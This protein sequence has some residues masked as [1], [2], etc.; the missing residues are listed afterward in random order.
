MIDFERELSRVVASSAL[1]WALKNEKS[2]H[3]A[4]I[5]TVPSQLCG[6]L[7][8]QIKFELENLNKNKIE[9]T[10]LEVFELQS[11]K[12]LVDLTESQINGEKAIEKRNKGVSCLIIAPPPP[13]TPPLP[14]EIPSSIL[15]A[16]EILDYLQLI[17]LAAQEFYMRCGRAEV[18]LLNSFE[19]EGWLNGSSTRPGNT[20]AWLYIVAMVALGAERKEIGRELWRVGLIPDVGT[21]SGVGDFTKRLKRNEE[22]VKALGGVTKGKT[23]SVRLTAVNVALTPVTTRVIS[24]LSLR[25]LTSAAGELG[26]CKS[27][28]SDEL[29]LDKWDLEPDFGDLESLSILPFR[30]LTGR[31]TSASKLKQDDPKTF[32]EA[33]FANVEFTDEGEVRKPPSVQVH[34]ETNPKNFVHSGK[35]RVSLVIPGAYRREDEPPLLVKI[36]KDRKERKHSL[37]L[38]ISRDDLP[39]GVF[40]GSLLVAI[41][42]AALSEEDDMVMRLKNGR[43][44]SVESDEFELRFATDSGGPDDSAKISTDDSVSPA[45]AI[46]SVALGEEAAPFVRGY[47]LDEKRSILEIQFL[48]SQ[49]RKVAIRTV[50]IIPRLLQIQKKLISDCADSIYVKLSLNSNTIDSVGEQYVKSTRIPDILLNARIEY[51]KQVKVF[52]KTRTAALVETLEWDT[53]VCTALDEYVAIYKKVLAECDLE[54]AAEILLLDTVQ[55]EVNVSREPLRTTVIL[56]THP[57]RSLWLREYWFKLMKWHQQVLRLDVSERA[58]AIDIELV[59]RISL[60]NLPFISKAEGSEFNIYLDEVAFGYGIYVSPDD[61]DHEAMVSL[62]IAALGSDRSQAAQSSRFAAVRRNVAQY[63]EHRRHPD[64]LAIATLNIGDGELVSNL[65]APYFAEAT[66][67][68]SAKSDFRLQVTAYSNSHWSLKPAKK[69]AELQTR[70]REISRSG[71]SHLS[72]LIGLSIRPRDFLTTDRH[73]VHLSVVRG[74]ATGEIEKNSIDDERMSFLGGLITGTQTS[75]YPDTR[76]WHVT[77]TGAQELE[78]Q[79]TSLHKLLIAAQGKLHSQRE[80]SLGLSITLSPETAADIRALH[81]RSDRV[82][83]LDRY[84][85][86]DW[87]INSKSLGLGA[88]YVLDYTPDFVEGLA[89]R[90]IVTTQHPGEADRVVEKAM[91][92]MG[93]DTRNRRS[94]VIENLNFVSGRLVLRLMANSSYAYES[95]GLAVVIAVLRDEGDLKKWFVI[96]I[97]S[98]LEIFGS[99]VGIDFENRRRCDMLLVSFSE[100]TIEIRCVEVKERRKL[101]ISDQLRHRI[102]DQLNST[103]GIIKERY[104]GAIDSRIDHELQEAHFSSILHH[105]INRAGDHRLLSPS[106]VKI[107][108]SLVDRISQLSFKVTKEA[109]VVSIN[110]ESRRSEE[111]DDIKIRYLTGSD[112]ESTSFSSTAEVNRRM[113]QESTLV[114]TGRV[115]I[116]VVTNIE[117]VNSKIVESLEPIPAGEQEL[118]TNEQISENPNGMGDLTS[119][120]R[121]QQFV[122]TLPVVTF[123]TDEV[124]QPQVQ[125]DKSETIQ[126]DSEIVETA[127]PKLVAVD[128]GVDSAGQ[129]VI[130]NVSTKGSP[131]A[132]VLGITGQGKSVTTRHVISTFAE[133]GLA[134]LVIDVHGDMAA[135]PPTGASVLDVREFGLGFSPFYLTDHGVADISECAFEIAEVFSYVCD[136]GEMQLANVFKAIKHAYAATGWVNGEVGE[137]LPTIEEFAVQV[138]AIEKG[139]RGRNARERLLPLTDF[140][141]FQNSTMPFDP[142][143]SGGG[144]IVDLHN[145]KLEKV[146]RAATSLVLRKVYREMFLWPQDTSLKLAVILDEAHRIAK[147]PTLPKLLKEGRK[148]GVACFVA[149]QSFSDFDDEVMSNAGTKIVFRTNFPESKDVSG[150]IRGAEKIDFAKQ[151]E[152]LSVGEAFVSTAD[153]TRARKCKMRGRNIKT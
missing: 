109:Y 94:Q 124:V 60:S 121:G 59:N 98:H 148:Y 132:F 56:P 7:V 19:I 6:N 85:G 48:D 21:D 35:W 119:I 84:V 126:G 130:W 57:L 45:A 88:S 118:I 9:R 27:L 102:H 80:G 22:I 111:I 47:S 12:D 82:L 2:E 96:P 41:E 110:S 149:S 137:R 14:I 5:R 112:L 115:E 146:I 8:S 153:I 114:S 107:Y 43:N 70:L 72:P 49:A 53:E 33:I 93:L 103:E 66:D 136:L 58:S 122:P 39:D 117:D 40:D 54:L 68:N 13:L 144:L 152:Q 25:V 18:E 135:S 95:I 20:E 79:I 62:T 51:F 141:L 100:K 129:T 104:F 34:W 10:E 44:A 128:L 123:E 139:A 76:S 83:T 86:L 92:E 61:S 11:D 108:H 52:S 71:L 113:T 46:L 50:R 74:I 99:N 1:A 65:M 31:V 116:P 143:G 127:A 131:H 38:D 64:A 105:Y 89:E 4:L 78:G 145:F 90:L 151:I 24:I 150:L 26:W 36:I 16:F 15:S 134:S 73:N 63:I 28:I 140:G 133:Q 23:P 147:D 142:R 3:F 138:E 69:L 91:L 75:H 67:L 81:N 29:T 120:D 37:K 77:P 125:V 106:T 97:D 32:S 101:P 55:I 17:Q 42:V 30:D 87:F